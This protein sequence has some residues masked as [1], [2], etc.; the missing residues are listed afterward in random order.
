[1]VVGCRGEEFKR[2]LGMADIKS[3]HAAGF[4]GLDESDVQ[5]GVVNPEWGQAQRVEEVDIRSPRQ[6]NVRGFSFSLYD[7]CSR[8]D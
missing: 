8:R 3:D 2:S 6:V 5:P 4:A 1:M 7:S